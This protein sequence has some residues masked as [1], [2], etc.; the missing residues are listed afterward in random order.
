MNIFKNKT[1][2]G[3]TIIELIVVIAI[4]TVLSAIVMT[5]VTAYQKKA[6]NAARLST[7]RNYLTAL[8]IAYEN[9]GNYPSNAPVTYCC[10]GS[11]NIGGQCWGSSSYAE[12][13]VANN[14]LRPFFAVPT[15]KYPVMGSNGVDYRGILYN[16]SGGQINL[17][18]ILEGTNQSCGIVNALSGNFLNNTYCFYLKKL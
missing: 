18:W 17:Y 5:N 13:T 9:N 4:I 2:K 15:D 14:T 3:F 12:C 10:L 7:V 6:R 16:Y 8:E 11:G 1:S